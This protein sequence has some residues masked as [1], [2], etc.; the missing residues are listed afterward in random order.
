MKKM[1][2]LLPAD[3]KFDKLNGR[4]RKAEPFPDLSAVPLTR[5][6]PNCRALEHD[7]EVSAF[8]E[9]IRMG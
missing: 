1:I 7:S 9:Q 6:L 2:H 3:Q 8:L 4:R 5:R